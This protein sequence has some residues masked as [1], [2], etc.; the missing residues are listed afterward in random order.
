MYGIIKSS[1]G[2]EVGDMNK[3]KMSLVTAIINLAT[4][5]ILLYKAQS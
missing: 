3:E 2:K 1:R 5:I 4:A